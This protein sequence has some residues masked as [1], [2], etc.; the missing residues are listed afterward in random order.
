MRKTF[1]WL[2]ILAASTAAFGVERFPPPDFTNG[3]K[4][5]ITPV[6]APRADL[7]NYL[8]IGVLV[9]ALF[10]AA[11]FVILKRSRRGIAV[12]AI[13]SL[14]YF[15]L[16][17]QGCVC[18]I[19]AI[20][21]IAL[22]IADRTYALPLV[23]GAFFLLPLLFALFFGRVFCAAV[24]PL[25]AAQDVVLRKPLKVP[26]WLVQPL[27]LL[28]WIYLGAAVL[29]A[30]TG[31]TFLICRYDPFVAFFRLGGSMG[32]LIFGAA[33]L[34]LGTVVG[35]PYCRFL[36][37]YGAILRLIAPLAKWRVTITPD[38][39]V[40]CRLCEESC[41]FGEIRVPTMDENVKRREGKGRLVAL[42]TLLPVMVAVGAWLGHLGSV[43][44]SRVHP[45]VRLA[46]RIW[47]EEHGTVKGT[48]N[49][50]QAFYKLGQPNAVAYKRALD[51][52][53]KYRLGSLLFGG[54]VGLVIGLKLIVLSIRRRRSDY[55]A[56]SS[57]CI[58]CGRCYWS[59]PVERARLGDPEARKMLEEQEWSR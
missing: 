16:Y 19:G 32:M 3:Y 40:K 33:T 36:C 55:E 18:S 49:E 52:E 26:G 21:N 54:W 30:A 53:S 58:G 24:C 57:G 46:Q 17:R 5:P 43:Q 45:S 27:S 6:P 13:F 23:A 38:Q 28:P 56:D 14:I 1:L 10:F 15:G 48:T 25:G 11:Y 37:P 9:M 35:R 41:P 51:I 4:L 22:A 7:F 50:S 44:M 47:Q 29:Y 59:C 39:C 42:L 31:T 34:L 20:Q 12:L 2:S 8:D